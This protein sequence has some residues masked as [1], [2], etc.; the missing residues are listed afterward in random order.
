MFGD[1]NN[2]R[3]K[4]LRQYYPDNNRNRYKTRELNVGTSDEVRVSADTS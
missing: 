3:V 2:T 1:C 4:F